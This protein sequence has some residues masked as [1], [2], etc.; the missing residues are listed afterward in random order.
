MKKAILLALAVVLFLFVLGGVAAA[1]ASP[2]DIYDD[3]ALHGKLTGTY[4]KA[5]LLAYLNDA[6]IHQ[7]GDATIVAALDALIKDM[8]ARN[9]FPFTGAQLGLI[10]AVAVILIA[11]G[12]TLRRLTRK[13]V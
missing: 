11:A 3:Y 12:F 2:Q 4:T 1:A 6:N 5:E 10:A 8:M 13:R 9:Q 7:Y